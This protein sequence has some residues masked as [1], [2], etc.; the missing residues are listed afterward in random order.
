V[1]SFIATADEAGLVSELDLPNSTRVIFAYRE[2]LFMPMD[3]DSDI[4]IGDELVLVTT[5]DEHIKLHTRWGNG[6]DK[7]ASAKTD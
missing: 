7:T 4:E 2:N 1:F 6:H 3:K 5:L